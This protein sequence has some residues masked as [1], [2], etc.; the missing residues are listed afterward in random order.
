[1]AYIEGYFKAGFNQISARRH[2]VLDL[3]MFSKYLFI[4]ELLKDY[5]PR[6]KIELKILQIWQV[7]VKNRFLSINKLH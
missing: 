1:M 5:L 4:F 7:I 6:L 3:E 2:P